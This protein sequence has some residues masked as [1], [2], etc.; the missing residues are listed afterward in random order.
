MGG[1]V[2]KRQFTEDIVER[3]CFVQK[4]FINRQLLALTRE[5]AL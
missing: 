4:Y 1:R 3:N 5:D 2:L